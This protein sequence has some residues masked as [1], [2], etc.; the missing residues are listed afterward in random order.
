MSVVQELPKGVAEAR[1]APKGVAELPSGMRR[2]LPAFAVIG[3]VSTGA[4]LALYAAIRPAVGVQFANFIALLVTAIANTAANR[5]YTFQVRGSAD[6][7]RH[8][9]QGGAAFLTG[10]LLSSGAL[11]IL[12]LAD[13]KASHLVEIGALIV[14]NAAATLVRFLL[15][16]IWV[17]GRAGR[18]Q[19]TQLVA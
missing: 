2:Q 14:A 6:A 3:V 16:R 10:I 19:A 18:G 17:F 9:L 15:L 7:L 13:P 11:E 4:Y 8:Q 1:A 5:R 12:H